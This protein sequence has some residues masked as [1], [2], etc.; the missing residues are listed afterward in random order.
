MG[1]NYLMF[2]C[3]FIF[4]FFA[5]DAFPENTKD[6]IFVAVD[7]KK[8]N[9]FIGI[10]HIT[11]KVDKAPQFEGGEKE[12]KKYVENNI[13]YPEEIIT[14][15]LK[16]IAVRLAFVV[17]KDGNIGDV[18]IVKGLTPEL[19]A[20]A[21]RVVS[22]FPRMIPGQ[23]D[24]KA[25]ATIVPYSIRFDKLEL[26]HKHIDQMPG[27]PGGEEKMQFYIS[28]KVIYPKEAQQRGDEGRVTVRFIVD[29]TGK[30][31]DPK[32]IRG[33]S[34]LL[35]AEALRVV[36][37]MPRWNPGILD[38]KPVPVYF[39]IPIVFRLKKPDTSTIINKSSQDSRSYRD[40]RGW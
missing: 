40:K 28:N 2:I 1:N 27:F 34:S 4:I 36:K 7:S 22:S 30:L 25:V 10:E 37:G 14:D 21:V 29:K 16:G 11:V 15:S 20:E 24:G 5:S 39:T 19:D 32:V 13:R 31:K 3:L 33:V 26:M 8:L 18:T 17:N 38:G 6:T 23:K 9:E 12:L 35:D